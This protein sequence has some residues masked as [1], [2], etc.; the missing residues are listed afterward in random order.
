MKVTFTKLFYFSASYAK[1]GKI[2]GHNYTLSVTTDFLDEAEEALLQKKIEGSLIK[3]LD[4]RDFG[5]DVSF[6]KGVE[7]TDEN[8]LKVFWGIVEKSIHPMMLRSL[9]LE[10]DSRTKV[11]MS[12]G[13]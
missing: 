11:A 13:S 2:H 3:N 9:S 1:N 10:K 8:L 4:S 7:I 6:L 5:L 12:S